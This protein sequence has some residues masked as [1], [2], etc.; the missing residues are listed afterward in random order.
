MVRAEQVRVPVQGRGCGFCFSAPVPESAAPLCT[1]DL[2]QV[3][4]ADWRSAFV[5]DLGDPRLGQSG[6]TGDL[7]GRHAR[8]ERFTDIPLLVFPCLVDGPQAAVNGGAVPPD[9]RGENS[10]VFGIAVDLGFVR[11]HAAHT[12]ADNDRFETVNSSSNSSSR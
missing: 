9:H 5:A 11:K 12:T 8:V 3:E 10:D 2:H 1:F 7:L 4:H 6:Q